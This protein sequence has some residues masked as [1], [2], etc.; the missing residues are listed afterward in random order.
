MSH[1]KFI[2]ELGL[3]CEYEGHDRIDDSNTG[4]GRKYGA[5]DVEII[6]VVAPF[7]KPDAGPEVD[8]AADDAGDYDNEGADYSGGQFPA[9]VT[10]QKDMLDER[11]RYICYAEETKQ[12]RKM[13]AK[14][15]LTPARTKS[16][17]VKRVMPESSLTGTSLNKLAIEPISKIV[18]QVR[19]QGAGR[20]KSGAYTQYVSILSRT[21]TQPSGL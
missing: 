1:R 14:R 16:I 20:R 3:E 21:A 18:D 9:P 10:G 11:T 17:T 15:A 13:E 2:P 19:G 6:P 5:H 12:N 4:K 8:S 7:Q